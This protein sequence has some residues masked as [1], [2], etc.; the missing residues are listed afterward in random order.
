M[1]LDGEPTIYYNNTQGIPP[2][3]LATYTVFHNGY[4]IDMLIFDSK[5]MNQNRQK[6][7]ILFEQMVSTITF[8][9]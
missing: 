7:L 8:T 6:N 3:P 4:G 1:Y 2:I 9:N 5:L